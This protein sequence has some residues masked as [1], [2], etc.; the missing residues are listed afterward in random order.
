MP[1]K[2]IKSSDRVKDHGEVFT[3]QKTVDF[4]LDQPEVEEKINDLMATFL[5]PSA[6]EGAFLVELLKRKINVAAGNSATISEFNENSLVALSTLY[7]IEYLEDNVEM[8]VMNM[9][10]TF[11]ENYS[12]LTVKKYGVQPDDK[13]EKSAKVIINANMAQGDTLKRENSEG[14]PII[15]SEWKMIPGKINKV[16]RSE[17]TFESIVD[18]GTA[19]DTVVGYQKGRSEQLSLFDLDDRGSHEEVKTPKSYSVVKWID[20]YRQQVE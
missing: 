15:F 4:M 18:G 1:E 3:P 19:N 10:T 11:V 14:K 7:G 13:V 2:L 20:I 12:L 9:I 17:Y 6:G 5:E 16:Q 8:L